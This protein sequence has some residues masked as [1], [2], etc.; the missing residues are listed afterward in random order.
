MSKKARRILEHLVSGPQSMTEL[1]RLFGNNAT[2]TEIEAALAEIGP[3]IMEEST[4]TG[5]GWIIRL[6]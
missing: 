5:G 3:Q 4:G 1:H 6:K 2:R